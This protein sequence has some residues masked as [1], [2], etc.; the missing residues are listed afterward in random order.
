[1]TAYC[2]R[3]LDTIDS[4]TGELNPISALNLIVFGP[5]LEHLDLI[6]YVVVD[7]LK[8]KWNTFIKREFFKQMAMFTVFFS[9]A[10]TAFIIRPLV[11]EEECDQEEEETSSG[12][13][14]MSPLTTDMEEP[15]MAVLLLSNATNATCEMVARQVSDGQSVSIHEIILIFR[16]HFTNCY[17]HSI[18]EPMDQIRFAC[19]VLIV[20]FGF[21]YILKALR[22]LSF[23][24]I[25]IFMENMQLCPSRVCFLV[26]CVLLQVTMLFIYKVI[27]FNENFLIS[28]FSFASLQGYFV[29][30]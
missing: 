19:E 12:N 7:L 9:L 13:L 18:E 28:I 23:L 26:S 21:L 2:D 27:Q 11:P 6:E 10:I 15:P 1:M 5:K 16:T 29:Y 3:Y 25:K 14:T 22:E 17:L 30:T 20:F 4:D 8:V 24:G